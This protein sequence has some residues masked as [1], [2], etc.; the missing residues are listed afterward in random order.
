MEEREELR[1]HC[2]MLSDSIKT[3]ELDSKASRETILRLVAAGKEHVK[4]R[5]ELGKL[6]TR[7]AE[8]KAS[9]VASEQE[10]VVLREQLRAAEE[11]VGGLE[12]ELVV[13][14]E[15]WVGHERVCEGWGV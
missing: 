15:R 7:V 8:E 6:Q 5:E 13:K 14:E 12:Q 3:A 4:D 1:Q 10:K 9:L 2:N 11:T